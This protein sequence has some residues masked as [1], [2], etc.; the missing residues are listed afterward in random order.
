MKIYL[1][2]LTVLLTVSCKRDYEHTS[3][4]I[5]TI[6]ESVYASGVVKSKNQY[7]VYSTVNGLLQNIFV[8]EGE[9]VRKGDPIMSILNEPSKLNAYNAK[10]AADYSD[11]YTNADKLTEAKVTIDF[12]FTKLKNDSLL[13][14]RQRNLKAQGVGSLL[15]LEQREL[16][17]QNSRTNYRVAQLRYRDLKRQL[18]FASNQSKTNL[19]ISTALENDYMIKASADGRVY[20]I[21]KEK[22]E[23]VNTVNP[24]AVLGDANEFLIE[25]KVDEYDIVSILQSQ[26]VLLTMDSYKDEVFKGTVVRIEPLMNEQTRSFTVTVDFF[27][28]PALLYP[29]LS[30]EANIIIR[31]KEKTLTIPRGFL[32]GDTAVMMEN[33]EIRKVIV[34]IKDYQKAEIKSGLSEQDVIYKSNP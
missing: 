19:R 17:Y 23:F 5:E 31:S 26:D 20:K 24:V 3:P 28:K 15:D 18:G 22:G 27:T 7:Q 29:N 32:L 9:A 25:L 16:A 2:V 12:A 6:S 30:V 10:L 4:K 33:Q 21:L 8:K 13:M 11:L 34:G 1:L 14:V